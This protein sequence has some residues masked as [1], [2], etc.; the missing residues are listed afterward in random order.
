MTIASS[1]KI[2]VT[3]LALPE[4]RLRFTPTH[5]IGRTKSQSWQEDLSGCLN[6]CFILSKV[7]IFYGQTR[8][9]TAKAEMNKTIVGIERI[10]D[11]IPKLNIAKSGFYNFEPVSSLSSSANRI[12]RN[13]ITAAQTMLAA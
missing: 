5:S 7:D 9:S 3:A 13:L 1:F 11:C 12:Q 4:I 6:F 10:S 8:P 2:K